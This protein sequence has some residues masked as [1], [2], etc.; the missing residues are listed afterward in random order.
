MSQWVE[1]TV[2]ELRQ[3]TDE[4][5]SLQVR[6]DI[7]PFI[8]GQFTRVGREIDGEIIA[9]P[10]SFVNAPANPVLEFYFITVPAG[11]LS[12]EL[13]RLRPG[14]NILVSPRA[15]GFFILRELPDAE[16][17]WMLATGTAIG[18]FLSIL[19]TPEVWERFRRVVLVHSVR[20][21]RELTYRDTLEGLL[22]R[23]PEQLQVIPM[24]SRES[25]DHA[26]E[27]R[28]TQAIADGRLETRAG[29]PL[30]PASSQVMIC[31][32]PAMVH[33][34]THLLEQRGLRK[35]RRR[36]PG[37]ITTEQYWKE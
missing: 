34:T 12:H 35:N 2:V 27:G 18:P 4:L 9:R 13:I 30:D 31:G 1:G 8:A 20:T 37:H 28:I 6:A 25:V 15:A 11:P 33:D 29:L 24:V 17:L 19:G 10:Y 7:A 21:A 5:Y 32:N 22:Q 14:D 3:W 26:L 36:E 23:H 16:S